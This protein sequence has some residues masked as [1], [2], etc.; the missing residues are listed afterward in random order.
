MAAA[1]GFTLMGV[2]LF[3]IFD[4]AE[5][6]T[7]PLVPDA[8]TA[9]VDRAYAGSTQQLGAYLFQNQ[10]VNLE[11]AGLILTI[12]M[13]GAIIISRRRVL[14]RRGAGRRPPPS[15]TC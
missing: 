15:A 12:S 3:V 5:G 4:R 14:G 6:L 2:L 11:L 13:V 9:G 1:V 7:R 10:L 8:T